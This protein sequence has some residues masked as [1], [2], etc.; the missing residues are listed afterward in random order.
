MNTKEDLARKS[1][2]SLFL[3]LPENV[4][5]HHQQIV[6][7]AFEE[8]K[9][10]HSH[11]QS[12]LNIEQIEEFSK[13]IYLG[14]QSICMEKC[15][16]HAECNKA[17]E[18]SEK[19]MNEF[20]RIMEWKLLE[21]EKPKHKDRVLCWDGVI[22][23]PAIYFNNGSFTGFYYFTTFYHQHSPTI[24]TEVKLEE[25]HKIKNVIKWKLI[26]DPENK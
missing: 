24:Y 8:L 25:K 20:K 15:S 6:I 26:N 13:M 11:E 22:T 12:L 18:L 10:I 23:I 7:D 16:C 14:R 1:L 3:E 9:N 5:K 4:A 2:N 21:K 19:F 17:N